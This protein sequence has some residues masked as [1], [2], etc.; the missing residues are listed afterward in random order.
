MASRDDIVRFV[1]QIL[2]H[3]T[4]RTQGGQRVTLD[5]STSVITSQL[6]VDD[7]RQLHT[8]RARLKNGLFLM[9]SLELGFELSGEIAHA[10]PHQCGAKT[11]VALA[12]SATPQPTAGDTS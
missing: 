9:K 7:L 1:W 12:A 10:S 6:S 11:V 2:R 8:A 5:G 4:R 3:F